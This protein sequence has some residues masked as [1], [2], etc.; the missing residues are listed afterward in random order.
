VNA[1]AK[2]LLSRI[3][4]FLIALAVITTGIASVAGKIYIYRNYWGN[5]VLGPFAI[6]GGTLL[7][8]TL[9]FRWK[10]LEE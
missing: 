3:A 10:K 4:F 6:A 1:K 8:Y 2:G 7:L 9:I 5:R